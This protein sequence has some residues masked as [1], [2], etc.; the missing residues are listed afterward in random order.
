M[1]HTFLVSDESVNTHGY[2][3][4]TEGIDLT[5]FLL[6]PVMLYLHETPQ[7]IGRW[8][9]VVKK[10][11]KLFADA[12][13]DEDDTLAL[14]VKGKV[15]RGFLKATSLGIR[16]EENDVEN[17][18]DGNI[19]KKCE[20]IEISIVSIG[21]NGNALKLYKD[22]S[23]TLQLKLNELTAVNSV[24][25]FLGLDSN[26]VTHLQIVNTI[27]TLKAENNNFKEWQKN[28]AKEIIDFAISRCF[29]KEPL[30]AI[31]ENLFKVD[32]ATAKASI[33]SMMP[34]QTQCFLEL[35]ENAK[36]KKNKNKTIGKENWTLDD[37]RKNAPKELE[38]N[39][40]L[41]KKLVTKEF[42]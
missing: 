28:E 5:R 6:N 39:P 15:D 35:I 34:L 22:D 33:V 17:N 9:N 23:R 26:N 8:E 41:F 36:A 29:I 30:R 40:E 25:S 19:V 27:K 1:K 18:I 13:F 14:E 32:F 12:V 10:E 2:K 20:L 3:I 31:Y 37:Y 16:F 21:S 38:E 7:L 24:C 11:G 4:L 42:E